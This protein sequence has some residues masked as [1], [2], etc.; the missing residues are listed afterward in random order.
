MVSRIKY[1]EAAGKGI[2]WF[3]PVW[4]NRFIFKSALR[5]LHDLC[6]Q[7]VV[8]WADTTGSGLK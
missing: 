2:A 6:T 8:L 1:V 4:I 7:S 5:D 3:C